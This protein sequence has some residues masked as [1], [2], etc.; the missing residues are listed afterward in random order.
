LF[1]DLFLDHVSRPRRS[2]K[3]FDRS[4]LGSRQSDLQGVRFRLFSK[5][6]SAH[7]NSPK[8]VYYSY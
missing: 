5:G 1:C 6:F 2:A 3:F 4:E 7:D 8:K